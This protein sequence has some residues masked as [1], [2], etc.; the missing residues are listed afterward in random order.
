[1]YGSGASF[2]SVLVRPKMFWCDGQ[3]KGKI[4]S[5]QSQFSAAYGPVFTGDSI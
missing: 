2:A 3:L 1:V 5:W 4:V